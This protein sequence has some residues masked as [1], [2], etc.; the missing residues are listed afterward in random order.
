MGRE[1]GLYTQ[2]SGRGNLMPSDAVVLFAV[3]SWASNR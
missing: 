2:R 3:F 1:M